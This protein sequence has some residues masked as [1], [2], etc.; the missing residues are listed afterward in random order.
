MSCWIRKVVDGESENYQLIGEGQWDLQ[1]LVEMFSEW[2]LEN[3]GRL[4][5]ADGWIADIGFNARRVAS[6]GGPIIGT[7]LMNLCLRNHVEIYLS[8]YGLDDSQR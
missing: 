1:A 6:G 3:D 7:E 4:E 2:L 5:T 8:E